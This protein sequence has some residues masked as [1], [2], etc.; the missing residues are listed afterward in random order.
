M[1]QEKV[2]VVSIQRPETAF[3]AA[4]GSCGVE[5]PLF[6][7]TTAR[8]RGMCPDLVAN[9]RFGRKEAPKGSLR[10]RKASGCKLG[11]DAELGSDCQFSP[12]C[13]GKS[14]E[15]MLG[16]TEPVHRRYVKVAYAT[17]VSGMKQLAP[18]RRTWNTE[19]ACAPESER[20]CLNPVDTKGNRRQRHDRPCQE[21]GTAGTMI[22]SG[23]RA[24]RPPRK[25]A[26]CNPFAP[27]CREHLVGQRAEILRPRDALTS[28]GDTTGIHEA[29]RGRNATKR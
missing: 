4:P 20:R 3:Q 12:A 16:S 25:F 11:L 18:L 17:V 15:F 29:A 9:L 19:K 5:S 7:E 2:D 26:C 28:I 1:Q 23:I 6:V 8:S 13:P 14:A 22:A 27:N 24:G 21:G 10:V